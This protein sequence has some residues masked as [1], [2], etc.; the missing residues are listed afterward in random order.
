MLK[1]RFVSIKINPASIFTNIVLMKYGGIKR[2]FGKGGGIALPE[3]YLIKI[4]FSE[5]LG[6]IPFGPYNCLNA[7]VLIIYRRVLLNQNYNR[8]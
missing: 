5:D 6:L 3:P 2:Y 8:K 1:N 7:K 4:Y